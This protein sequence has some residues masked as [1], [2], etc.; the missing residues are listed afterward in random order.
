M[1]INKIKRKIKNIFYKSQ[2]TY[3]QTGEDLILDILLKDKPK[4]FYIDI[5]GNHPKKFNNTFLFYKKGWDG[6]NVEPNYSKIWL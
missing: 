5:G 1:I 3:S 2:T 6:I 4:G